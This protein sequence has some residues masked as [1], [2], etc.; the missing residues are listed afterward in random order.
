[1]KR[2]VIRRIIRQLKDAEAS[3]S[4]INYVLAEAIEF[5]NELDTVKLMDDLSKLAERLE[6]V[7]DDDNKWSSRSVCQEEH[8]GKRVWVDPISSC[9]WVP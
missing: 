7:I 2:N 6:F 4:D 9:S 5:N 1:M 3:I 8:P